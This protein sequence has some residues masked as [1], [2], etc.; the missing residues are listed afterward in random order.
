MSFNPSFSLVVFLGEGRRGGGG[1]TTMQTKA[2][3]VGAFRPSWTWTG[4]Y[5]RVKRTRVIY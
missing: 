5:N 1:G 3:W 2:G 4:A